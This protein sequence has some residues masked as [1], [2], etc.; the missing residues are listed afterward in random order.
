MGPV[1]FSVRQGLIAAPAIRYRDDLPKQL[2]EPIFQTCRR[3]L[4]PDFL[5]ERVQAIMNPYGIDEMPRGGSIAIAKEEDHPDIVAAKQA[6]L[7]CEWFR[8]YDVVE[9][10]YRELV[11][12]ESEF[13]P[14]DEK[15]RAYPFRNDLNEYFRYAGI[16]WQL[17]SDG[18]IVTR[19]DDAFEQT[20]HTAEQEL[21][22][23]GRTTA[24]NRLK[25]AVQGLSARPQADTAG[26]ISHATGAIECVLHDITGQATTLGR[27]LNRHT[28]LFPASMR[29]AL[30]G[31]WGFSSEEGARHGREGA[32][33]ARAD[34]EFIVAVSAAVTT[35]LNRKHPR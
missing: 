19:G 26:A 21:N 28:T 24:A 22:N 23:A 29:K 9:D 7:N 8:L 34:A 1:P 16:G 14:E 27:Y 6:L 10:L 30:D 18:Q 13:A 20:V 2:R 15:P 11:H 33:P 35:Y 3:Y 25:K 17:S 32:E 31:L 12:Y 4:P 5:W